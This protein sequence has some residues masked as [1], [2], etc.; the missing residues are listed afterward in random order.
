[1]TESNPYSLLDTLTQLEKLRN[2]DSPNSNRRFTR[3]VV[4]GDAELYPV[5]QNALSQA[6]IQ[7]ALRDMGGGGVGFICSQPIANG[8][9]WRI[10]FLS[11]GYTIGHQTMVVRHGQ[12]VLNG[13]Q[14][15][16][17]QFCVEPGMLV[18]MGVEPQLLP[19]SDDAD[20]PDDASFLAPGEVA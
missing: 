2:P 4:R 6:P 19:T 17:A 18:L 14:L 5:D 15:I 8:T 16:G 7:I 10:A 1:M 11:R 20:G 12:P 3:H 9:V 13:V